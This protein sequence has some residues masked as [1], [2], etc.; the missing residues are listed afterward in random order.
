MSIYNILEGG[1]TYYN[2]YIEE[3]FYKNISQDFL[4]TFVSNSRKNVRI[5]CLVYSF[6]IIVYKVTLHIYSIHYYK[7]L[8]ICTQ[9]ADATAFRI[10]RN[11]L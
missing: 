7:Y 6:T 3:C 9:S 10:L 11:I 5:V 1:P 8:S 2:S 4:N